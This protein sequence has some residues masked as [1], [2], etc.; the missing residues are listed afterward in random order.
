MLHI[1]IQFDYCYLH[2]FAHADISKIGAISE[3][4]YLDND[5]LNQQGLFRIIFS[6]TRS[7]ASAIH[8]PAFHSLSHFQLPPPIP[9]LP[10]HATAISRQRQHQLTRALLHRIFADT[11]EC[12]DSLPV[13]YPHGK[14]VQNAIAILCHWHSQQCDLHDLTVG[15]PTACCGVFK[16]IFSSALTH[17]RSMVHAVRTS[18]KWLPFLYYS[19]S[20]TART[21]QPG[22]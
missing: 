14:L 7:S 10:L 20:Q 9:S 12:I 13:N 6:S 16:H 21:S 1:T 8:H 2:L 19:H 5:G 3:Q 17:L 11:Y 15:L 18:R 4:R 22:H